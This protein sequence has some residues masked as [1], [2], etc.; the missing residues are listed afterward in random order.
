MRLLALL[1]VS[2]FASGSPHLAVQGDCECVATPGPCTVT[3]KAA[4]VKVTN[5]LVIPIYGGECD[6]WWRYFQVDDG[7]G[8]NALYTV[9]G[10]SGS[11]AGF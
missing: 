5:A 7:C 2:A 11:W 3:F 8:F 10:L 1:I 4:D 6:P 9:V